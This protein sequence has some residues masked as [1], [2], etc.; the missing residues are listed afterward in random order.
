MTFAIPRGTVTLLC[1]PSGSGKSSII[2]CLNGLI[3]HFHPVVLRGSV[4]VMGHEVPSMTLAEC[5]S[6]A[7]TVFQNPRT[8]FFTST[9]RSELAFRWENQA[10]DPAWIRERV[11]RD[12]ADAGITDL[13]D[14]NLL[15]CSGGQLQRVACAQAASADTPLLLFDEPT[16]NLSPRTID[17][18][19]E[20]LRY[21]KQQG[22]TIVIA[23]HR[24]YF[25]AASSTRRSSS[26][27]AASAPR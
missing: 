26:S 17:E 8:Q 20:R 12:A 3:P 16:S 25:R 11:L 19:T 2:Q 6:L 4:S 21:Y 18:F 14:K 1:G 13:L 22:R 15:Q 7:A 23:E 10:R 5:G 9:V 27:T 24:L